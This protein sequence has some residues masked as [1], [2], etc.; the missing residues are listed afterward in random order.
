MLKIIYIPK[1][2]IYIKKHVTKNYNKKHVTK[3]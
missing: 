2:N 1:I 3:N